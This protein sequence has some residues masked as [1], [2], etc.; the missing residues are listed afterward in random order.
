[1]LPND[2]KSLSEAYLS[3]YEPDNDSDILDEELLFLK[4]LK[5]YVMMN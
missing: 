1:M 3:I 2:I 5:S 4:V